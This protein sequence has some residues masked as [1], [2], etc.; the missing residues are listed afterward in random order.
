MSELTL[1]PIRRL[2]FRAGAKRVSDKAAEALIGK[3]E[4]RALRI[5]EEAW[6]LARHAGRSTVMKQDIRMAEKLVKEKK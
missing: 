2:F 6:N 5:A 3:M 1:Q 4:E